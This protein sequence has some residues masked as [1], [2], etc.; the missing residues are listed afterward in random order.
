M[1]KRLIILAIAVLIAAGLVLYAARVWWV[2]AVHDDACCVIA[3]G[4]AARKAE[5]G[6]VSDAETRAMIVHLID[7]GVI[8]GLLDA[9]GSPTDVNG[10]PFAVRH[11]EKVVSVATRPSFWDPFGVERRI[12]V[13]SHGRAVQ[14]TG[15]ATDR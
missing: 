9:D 1:R 15:P 3:L 13:G 4:I 7:A 2:R 10:N 14:Q 5:N 12:P 8:H 11:D 6:S